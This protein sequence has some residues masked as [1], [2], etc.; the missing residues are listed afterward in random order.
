MAEIGQFLTCLT[1]L[2][3]FSLRLFN[4]A[5]S[6]FDTGIGFLHQLL[7]FFFGFPQ[8]FFAGFLQIFYLRLVAGNGFFHMLFAL[9]DGLAFAFPISLVAHNVLQIFVGIDVFAADNL[10]SVGDYIFR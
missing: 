9:A 4:G 3:L 10:R 5:N 2:F 8:N 1:G 7:C 6:I